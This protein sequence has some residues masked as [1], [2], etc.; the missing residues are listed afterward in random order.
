MAGTVAITATTPSLGK[1]RLLLGLREDYCLVGSA[2]Q[3][4]A[5]LLDGLIGA[6]GDLERITGF[7]DGGN[8]RDRAC[9][10]AEGGV[11]VA[12]R[13]GAGRERK[14]EQTE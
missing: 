6:D 4:Y 13:C 9:D 10:K 7:H 5:H 11:E 2:V 8:G 12:S 1:G 14:H 3:H